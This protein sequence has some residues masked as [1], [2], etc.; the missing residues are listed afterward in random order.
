[1]TR[2][3][4]AHGDRRKQTDEGNFAIFYDCVQGRLGKSNKFNTHLEARIILPTP[5]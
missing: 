2:E 1:M 5:F 4:N 3:Q